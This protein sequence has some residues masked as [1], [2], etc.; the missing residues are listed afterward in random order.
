MLA[1]QRSVSPEPARDYGLGFGVQGVRC[2]VLG[3]GVSLCLRSLTAMCGRNP[4]LTI[5]RKANGRL[6]GADL[7]K[8]FI[9][10]RVSGLGFR[11]GFRV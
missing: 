3:L 8:V 10:F 2:R 4:Q 1:T 5:A 6:L 9:G 7:D 11:V